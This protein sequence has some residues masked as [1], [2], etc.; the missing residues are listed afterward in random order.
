MKNLFKKQILLTSSFF[1]LYPIFAWATLGGNAQSIENDAVNL[2]TVNNNNNIKTNTLQNIQISKTNSLDYTSYS[3]TTKN[4]TL[5]KEFIA[6]NQVFA[7]SWNGPFKTNVKQLLGQY[8]S[9]INSA[10]ITTS[11]HQA[12]ISDNQIE[13]SSG[14]YPGEFYGTAILKSQAPKGFNFKDAQ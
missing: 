7:I 4:N 5:I 9:N 10:P 8:F 11:I 2:S 1:C 12:Q 14:G 3:F 13:Y 6:N